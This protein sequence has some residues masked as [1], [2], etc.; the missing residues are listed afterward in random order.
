MFLPVDNYRHTTATVSFFKDRQLRLCIS[1]I[2]T[3]IY[4]DF[5]LICNKKVSYTLAQV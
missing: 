5:K 3:F 1:L 4:Y 2:N